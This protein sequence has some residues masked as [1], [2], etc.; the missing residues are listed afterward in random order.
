V[1]EVLG[2]QRR[3]GLNVPIV[4]M[5][6]NDERLQ[7]LATWEPPPEEAPFSAKS[8]KKRKRRGF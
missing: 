3:A 6:S 5:F 1:N 8:I 2:I 4:K 7:D